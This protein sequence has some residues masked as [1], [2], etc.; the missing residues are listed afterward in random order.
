M[1]REDGSKRINNIR[2]KIG[3]AWELKEGAMQFPGGEVLR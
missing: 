3:P 1:D 2:F